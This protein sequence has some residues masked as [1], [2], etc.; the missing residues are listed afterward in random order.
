MSKGTKKQ[1]YNSDDEGDYRMDIDNDSGARY[2]RRARSPPSR[3]M[4]HTAAVA[5]AKKKD[6]KAGVVGLSEE[7]KRSILQRRKFGTRPIS[8]HG[9]QGEMQSLQD[10]VLIV[11]R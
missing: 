6:K 9:K 8:Y 2:S 11:L 5:Q 10:P 4:G 3:P 7:Q 1:A